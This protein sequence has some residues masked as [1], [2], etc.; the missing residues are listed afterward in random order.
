M[1]PIEIILTIYSAQLAVYGAIW[2]GMSRVKLSRRATLHWGL[3]TL[4]MATST[5][6]ILLRP[7]LPPALAGAL[8]NLLGLTAV[9][10]LS[11]GVRAFVRRPLHEPASL[12]LAALAG[13]VVV[14]VNVSGADFAWTVIVTWL[15]TGVL[16][17]RAAQ[18]M[19]TGMAPEFGRGKA[20]ACSLPLLLLGLLL[21]GRGLAAAA[22]LHSGAQPLTHGDASPVAQMLAQ[23]VLVMVLQM[24]LG[25]MLVMRLIGRLRR[26]SQHDALTGL[27]NRR[28]LADRLAAEIGRQRR[29]PAPLA[30]L[31]LDLDHFKA[32]NDRHG[33]PAGDALLAAVAAVLVREVR[34]VDTVARMGGEEFALLLP[35]TD[36][37]GANRLGE[38]VCQALREL[39][40]DFEGQP[41]RVSA[42]IGAAA[43]TQAANPAPSAQ[44]ADELLRC[45]D[46]ALYLAKAGGRDRVVCAGTF[47]VV[48]PQACAP[49]RTA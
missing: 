47:S 3:A 6:A 31:A 12:V 13:L 28:V 38:R 27:F 8:P 15:T 20:Y 24:V 44:D 1:T 11:R 4:V 40:V 34:A 25:L 14:G 42:S 37:E 2:L 22:A 17:L 9:V 43:T 29:Q 46:R 26:L 36:L 48:E 23:M 49:R 41:L 19:G 39:V 35:G 16:L 10:L 30:L 33:H 21:L 5:M 18:E 7:A 32:V 45:A